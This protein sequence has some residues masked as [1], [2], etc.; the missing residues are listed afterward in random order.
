MD[1]NPIEMFEELIRSKRL[2]VS[3]GV[4]LTCGEAINP[5]IRLG[6]SDNIEVIFSSPYPYLL[7]SKLGPVPIHEIKRKVNSVSINKDSYTISIDDFPDITK[8]R[9]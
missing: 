7:I 3:D 4:I 1:K 6:Q 9:S 5:T 8:S 2:E